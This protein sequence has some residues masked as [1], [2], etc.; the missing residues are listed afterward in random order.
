MVDGLTLVCSRSRSL[1]S[2]RHDKIPN[3]KGGLLKSAFCFYWVL[4]VA[5]EISA[6]YV[7]ATETE[8]ATGLPASTRAAS[9]KSAAAET[10]AA[11]SSSEAAATAAET[12]ETTTAIA[13]EA[14]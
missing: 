5:L 1:S 7:T 13:S 10:A 2:E 14:A 12:A 8:T 3:K 11:K 9:G 6:V 4:I